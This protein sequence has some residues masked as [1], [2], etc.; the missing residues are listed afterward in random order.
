VIVG[1]LGLVSAASLAL[2]AGAG[3]GSTPLR[4]T[5]LQIELYIRGARAHELQALKDLEAGKI[6]AAKAALLDSVEQLKPALASAKRTPGFSGEASAINQAVLKDEA[7]QATISATLDGPNGY[8]A[9][10]DKAPL[11]KDARSRS[12]PRSRSGT[13]ATRRRSPSTTRTGSRPHS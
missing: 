1:L 3:G 4:L 10:L 8:H 6:A 9:H 7:P 2:S 13:P 12:Q 11:D 5:P